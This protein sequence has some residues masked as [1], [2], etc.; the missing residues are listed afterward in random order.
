MREEGNRGE[1]Q[2]SCHLDFWRRDLQ[3]NPSQAGKIAKHGQGM[4]LGEAFDE[5][6]AQ[7]RAGFEKS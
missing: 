6:G 2:S 5:T 3:V 7:S 4:G 1:F